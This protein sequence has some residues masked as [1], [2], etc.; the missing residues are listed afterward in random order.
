MGHGTQ[1][2]A[3]RVQLKARVAAAISRVLAKLWLLSL[4]EPCLAACAP[5]GSQPG[6]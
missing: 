5:L 1:G 4:L 6:H 2:M 3:L